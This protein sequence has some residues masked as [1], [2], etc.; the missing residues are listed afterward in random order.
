MSEYLT[1][2]FNLRKTVIFGGAVLLIMGSV[3]I[4]TAWSQTNQPQTK[5]KITKAN[6]STAKKQKLMRFNTTKIAL[7]DKQAGITIQSQ[8]HVSIVIHDTSGV[9]QDATL[10]T[11]SANSVHLTFVKGGKYLVTATKG[12]VTEKYTLSVTDQRKT[13][14]SSTSES[15][16][17]V[18][19][20]IAPAVATSVDDVTTS[21]SVVDSGVTYS[22]A[23]K[24]SYS[25][26]G[27]EYNYY[28]QNDVTDS[29]VNEEVP[30]DNT[31]GTGNQDDATDGD[32]NSNGSQTTSD[33]TD[34]PEGNT[35]S[36][37]SSSNE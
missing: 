33:S 16:S 2:K 20:S 5:N 34:M 3:G 12:N 8:K 32:G 22:Q 27:T 24:Q 14:S 6:T 25:D 28:A 29:T 10:N 7:T 23:P 30:A 13:P 37:T 36:E 18:A 35:R 26:Y 4:T 15:V 9:L 17:S 19:E 31:V 1:M 21:S 11:D